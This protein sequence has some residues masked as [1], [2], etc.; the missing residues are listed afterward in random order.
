MITIDGSQGEGGG[1]IL[2]TALALAVV[3]GRSLHLTRI[4]AGRERPGLQ[5][6]HLT[7]VQAAAQ[8]SRARVTGAA[9]GSQEITFE[10]GPLQPGTHEIRIGSAGSTS[11]VLQTVLPALLLAGVP[12]ELSL[13]GGTH[14]PFAPPFPFLE[15]SFLP[16]LERIGYRATL[17]LEQLLEDLRTRGVSKENF[18]ERL[19]VLDGLPM[20]PIGKIA[21]TELRADIRRRLASEGT[22]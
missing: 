13:E 4:R 22:P 21:K 3:T 16:L 20:S 1:Q 9:L 8:I 6:Q 12:S 5:R 15:Q 14:N 10:P 2:R 11:L 7:A 17:T 19:I 18:P